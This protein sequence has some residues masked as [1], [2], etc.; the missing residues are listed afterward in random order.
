MTLFVTT[1]ARTP[2][3]RTSSRIGGTTSCA[4]ADARSSEHHPPLAANLMPVP[5]PSSALLASHNGG[6]YF[7]DL[8]G[9]GR[10]HNKLVDFAYVVGAASVGTKNVVANARN[11]EDGCA[12][13]TLRTFLRL[14]TAACASHSR[15]P[16]R[17]A[18]RVRYAPLL[19]YDAAQRWVYFREHNVR[20]RRESRF[21][22]FSSPDN[23]CDTFFDTDAEL[24]CS[25]V[26][27]CGHTVALSC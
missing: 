15:R 17:P 16:R 9:H 21:R 5:K 25:L 6:T 22:W 3:C 7:V 23:R 12:G 1:D 26:H 24:S 2:R 14:T 11:V 4:R 13:K 18:P 19:Y 10:G 27:K 20:I 8:P